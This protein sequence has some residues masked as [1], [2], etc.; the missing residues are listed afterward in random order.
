MVRVSMAHI[1]W[2]V[3]FSHMVNG[4]APH[5]VYA[6][7]SMSNMETNMHTNASSAACIRFTGSQRYPITHSPIQA[8]LS[9]L[10]ASGT[11]ILER[12]IPEGC[13]TC[14]DVLS[15]HLGAA[16]ISSQKNG[17]ESQPLENSYV[18][19]MSYVLPEQRQHLSLPQPLASSEIQDQQ[20]S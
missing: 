7:T 9:R 16:C 6:R 1:H 14:Y 19:P 12:S 18:A 13:S 2:C 15:S 17:K 20:P 5:P 3:G 8:S 4:V 10:A 11:A